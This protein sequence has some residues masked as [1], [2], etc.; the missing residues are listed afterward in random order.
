MILLGV[1]IFKS[2]EIAY[3]FSIVAFFITFFFTFFLSSK[4]INSIKFFAFLFFLIWGIYLINSIINWYSKSP[5]IVTKNRLYGNYIIDT[6]YFRGKNANWQYHHFKIKIEQ[7]SLK[8]II[9]KNKFQRTIAKKTYPILIEESSFFIF[10]DDYYSDKYISDP[11]SKKYYF[12]NYT[13]WEQFKRS[14]SLIN[15]SLTHHIIKIN[16]S[17]LLK[18]HDF[19]LIFFSTK[20]GNM[21]FKKED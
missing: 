13:T 11:N 21:Y 18:P 16:P 14:D 9:K 10:H 7:D 5:T 6:T 2:I 1:P 19:I 12:S 3:F 17:I 20:Y 4:L 8:L 15:D